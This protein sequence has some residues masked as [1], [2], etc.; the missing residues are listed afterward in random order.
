M[1]KHVWIH[2][3]FKVLVSTF[4]C[5]CVYVYW[6]LCVYYSLG[7]CNQTWKSCVLVCNSCLHLH[8]FIFTSLLCWFY[9]QTHTRICCI[10][11]SYFSSCMQ[12]ACQCIK[13]CNLL[14][15]LFSTFDSIF[16]HSLSFRLFL[17]MSICICV[18]LYNKFW[19]S[20]FSIV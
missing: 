14:F 15:T 18:W 20:S 7:V 6:V 11:F 2:L 13:F 9:T 12:M 16:T 1:L 10:F 4:V 19:I 8:V 17:C 3:S 5:V